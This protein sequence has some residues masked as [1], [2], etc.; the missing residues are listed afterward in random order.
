MNYFSRSF[1]VKEL[2]KT[3]KVTKELQRKT[4][5]KVKGNYKHMQ[6]RKQFMRDQ[7]GPQFFL[8]NI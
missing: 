2:W 5:E 4:I 1:Y 6:T 8:Y 7:D 3:C